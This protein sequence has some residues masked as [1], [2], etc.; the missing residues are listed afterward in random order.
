MMVIEAE[1]TANLFHAGQ[2]DAAIAAATQAVRKAPGDAAARLLLAELLLFAGKLDRADLLLDA[3]GTIDPK[4]ALPI[5]EFRQ[6]LRA[7]IARRQ[8]WQEGR[9]PEFLGEPSSTERALLAAI[10]ALQAG[11]PK[12]AAEHA[13]AAEALR[14]KT[15]VRIGAHDFADFRDADDLCAGVLE[16]LTATGKYFWIPLARVATMEFHPP[17]RPRDLFWRRTTLNV[18]NGPEGDVYLPAIYAAPATTD[19]LR[20]GRETDWT[21]EAPV[22]G[23]GQRLFVAG[24]EAFGIMELST[25]SCGATP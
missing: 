22:R 3:A 6:L 9:L 20:L 15:P 23:I 4:A 19:A 25:L 12:Q 16:V 2:I 18:E 8:L 1:N 10:V 14:E 21:K 5:A 17:R 7:E 11:N 13:A 24:D